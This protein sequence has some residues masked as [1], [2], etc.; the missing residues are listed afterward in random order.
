MLQTDTATLH[1]PPTVGADMPLVPQLFCVLEGGC[2]SFPV[3]RHALIDL[4]EIKL[5]RAAAPHDGRCERAPDGKQLAI[6]IAD[7]WLSSD[8][9]AI[10]R[11][12]EDF[13]FRDLRSKNGS[14]I[15]G[16]SVETATLRDG[17]IIELGQTFFVFRARA[18]LS[19]V[20]PR[21][22]VISADQVVPGLATLQA[23]LNA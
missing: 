11:Q 18:M 20:D 10:S 3:S 4:D 9:A 19:E 5:G 1:F 12:G 22:F 7:R 2:P 14:R 23:A 15:N 6:R 8:H 13:V 16:A 17:D 21:D